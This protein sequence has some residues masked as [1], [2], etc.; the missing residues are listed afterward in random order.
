MILWSP[1]QLFL[2]VCALL[3]FSPAFI[4]QETVRCNLVLNQFMFILEQN[5]LMFLVQMDQGSL[6]VLGWSD[7]LDSGLVTDVLLVPDLR[8]G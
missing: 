6:L 4:L 1:L 3:F 2:C 7:C 8:F 5:V